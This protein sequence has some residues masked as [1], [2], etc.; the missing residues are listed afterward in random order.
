MSNKYFTQGGFL[1]HN[2]MFEIDMFDG[3]H[4]YKCENSLNKSCDPSHFIYNQKLIEGSFMDFKC[5]RLIFSL[6]LNSFQ[7]D[8]I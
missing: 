1:C 3:N 4:D 5:N 6:P 7:S 2:A 8:S